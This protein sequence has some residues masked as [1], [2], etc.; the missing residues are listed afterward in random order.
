MNYDDLVSK[1]IEFRDAKEAIE[2]KHKAKL[3][4]INEAMKKI[5]A[6][7]LEEFN[8]TGQSSAKTEHGTA[9][10]MIRT[11][12]KVADRDTFLDF[13]R[14]EEAWQFIESR[15]NATAVTEYVEEHDELPPGVDMS[16]M[17]WVSFRRPTNV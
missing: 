15:V 8:A 16:K 4:R 5:E 7:V 14:E 12:A 17:A 11:S 1:Y 9:T 10:K 6:M 2:K 13:V 3:K